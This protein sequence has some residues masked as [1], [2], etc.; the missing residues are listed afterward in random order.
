[1]TAL[2]MN[3]VAVE[4]KSN[5]GTV[6]RAVD[7]VSLTVEPGQ[8]V[9]LVGESGC[10]K[11]SLARV[12]SGL[13]EP[14]AGTVTLSGDRVRPL[15]WRRRSAAQLGLQMVFQ[16]PYSSLNPRRRVGEQLM[17]GVP[18]D[19]RGSARRD[20][21]VA[22]L[23]RVGMPSSAVS[24]YPHQFSGGQLQ[25]IAIARALVAEPSVLIA[26][27]PVTA[28]D[29]S[30]QVQVVNTLTELVK[31]LGVGML[32]ISHDLSLVR[33]IADVTAVM[34]LGKVVEAAPTE[35]LWTDPK[36]PYT[37]ALIAAIPR[38]EAGVGLPQTLAGE[39]PDPSNRP[40]GCSFAPRCSHA[41]SSCT[42]EPSLLIDGPG[43]VACWL[44]DRPALATTH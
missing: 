35:R 41:F 18:A 3:D 8:I 44:T 25:R 31:E 2:Q 30:S 29:A 21:A 20:R 17:D 28:L 38:V 23:N 36:H 43:Q 12:A 7:G 42:T 10:G 37:R 40:S 13:I 34:Y 5:S 24:R 19:V 22:Q 16:N 15:G 39:V 14:A 26:D 32:F 9:G 27:E 6:V 4:Y 11:S 33:H 1:M